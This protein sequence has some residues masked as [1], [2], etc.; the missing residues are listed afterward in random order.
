MRRA[1]REVRDRLSPA[2]RAQASIAVCDRLLQI[3]EIAAARTL[4]AFAA[5]RGEIDV[6]AAALAR[7]QAGTRVVYPRVTADASPRLKFHVVLHPADLRPGAFGILEP[8]SSA[9]E[10]AV[11]D[12][13]VVLAPGLAFD[14]TGRRLGYGGGYYDEVAARVRGRGGMGGLLVGVGF[15]FQVMDKDTIPAGAG[16]IDVDCI[17]TDARLIRC[18]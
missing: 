6:L 13:D 2:E 5:A 8:A 15:D 7:L 9:A 3:P 1:V 18:H 12:I 14:P 17:A 4:A 10:V 16:D 11:E